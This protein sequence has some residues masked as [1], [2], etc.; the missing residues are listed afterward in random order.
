MTYPKPEDPKDADARD[1]PWRHGRK[2]KKNIYA[3]WGPTEDDSTDIG[4]MDSALIAATA[5]SSVNAIKSIRD[6]LRELGVPATDPEEVAV[7]AV[8]ALQQMHGGQR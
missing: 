4:R 5:I 3:Q 7:L 2:I 6:V 1:N 8:Q